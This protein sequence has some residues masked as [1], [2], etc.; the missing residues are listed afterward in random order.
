MHRQLLLLLHVD[1]EALT[2]LTR[3][4]ALSDGALQTSASG[5]IATRKAS[6]SLKEALSAAVNR[7]TMPAGACAPAVHRLS[8]LLRTR[9]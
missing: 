8:S 1:D 7:H 3:V 9:P 4:K 2:V 5:A 6:S